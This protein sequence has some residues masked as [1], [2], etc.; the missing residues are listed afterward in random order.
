M[1]HEFDELPPRATQEREMR[2]IFIQLTRINGKLDTAYRDRLD[3]SKAISDLN[4]RIDA[5]E[6]EAME[7]KIRNAAEDERK[8]IIRYVVDAILL[9][10]S[11]AVGAGY[12]FG[13]K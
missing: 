6:E 7:E 2:E 12:F 4:Q 9:L 3:Q 11:A 5:M 10:V 13:G 1:S 8:R